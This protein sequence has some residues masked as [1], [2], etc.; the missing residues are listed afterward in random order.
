MNASSSY[1]ENTIAEWDYMWGPRLVK[2]DRMHF[3]MCSAIYFLT[4]V[5]L[6]IFYSYGEFFKRYWRICLFFHRIDCS[7]HASFQC[8]K[9]QYF[10]SGA[11]ERHVVSRYRSSKSSGLYILT[12]NI[13]SRNV[14]KYFEKWYKAL[15]IQPKDKIY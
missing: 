7:F 6:Q 3:G 9:T 4:L 1:D 8:F 13:L 2:G 12:H 14:P 11:T 5:R 15:K 10:Y